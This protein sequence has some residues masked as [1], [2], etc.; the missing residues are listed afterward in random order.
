[1]ALMTLASLPRHSEKVSFTHSERALLEGN[2]AW[3]STL[4]SGFRCCFG[5]A[6]AA[7]YM[8]R[9]ASAMQL[10]GPDGLGFRQQGSVLRRTPTACGRVGGRWD[11]E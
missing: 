5:H 7:A 9:T 3:E 6:R 1:M 10:Q 11:W 8:T 4:R 2:T